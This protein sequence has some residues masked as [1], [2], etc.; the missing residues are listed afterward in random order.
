MSG[1][2]DPDRPNDERPQ[3]V[4]V[5]GVS[6]SGKTTIAT[7][8]ATRLGW[9]FAEGD[10]F[11]PEANVEKMAH[12]V[13]LTDEDRWP[14][15]RA[16]GA[17]M[18]EHAREGRS[19]V[20]TCSALKRAYRDLLREGRDRVRFC[21]IDVPVEELERR[22]AVRTGHYMP[23]SLLPSQLATL[24]ALQ[25]DEP[26]VVVHAHGDPQHVVTEAFEKLGLIDQAGS[27]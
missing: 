12:G 25:P 10:D 22:L 19:A 20:V 14:W 13:P 3:F 9:D 17:W 11:H 7:A 23:A 15:L 24:E 2:P 18:D 1:A 27:A 21:C 5:M 26:G 4:I 8:L 16:I 6:G